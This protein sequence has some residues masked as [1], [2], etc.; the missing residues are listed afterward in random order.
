MLGSFVSQSDPQPLHPWDIFF[1]ADRSFTQ[2]DRE[3]GHFRINQTDSLTIAELKN[4]LAKA[5]EHDL[6]G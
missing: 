2:F 1:F 5:I 3:I 4:A 6:E